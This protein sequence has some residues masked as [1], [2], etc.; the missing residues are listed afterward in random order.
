[1]AMSMEE[2]KIHHLVRS[3]EGDWD[4]MIN[5][6]LV[7]IFQVE[8][9]SYTL[10]LLS[11]EQVGHPR[12]RFWMVSLTFCP[13]DPIAIKGAFCS[14][15]LHMSLDRGHPVKSKRAI[16]RRELPFSFF[17]MPIGC[18]S[19]FGRFVGMALFAPLP[20]QLEQQGVHPR[21]RAF[22]AY[23]RIVIGPSSN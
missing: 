5:L 2:L 17:R 7:S 12:W 3:S 19:P 16:L 14:L 10:S 23:R 8:V 11:F 9:T 15:Y 21:K 6:D 22:R 4:I 1:M 13:V 20:K 18:G